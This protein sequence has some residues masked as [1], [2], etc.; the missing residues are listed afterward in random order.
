MTLTRLWIAQALE[1]LPAERTNTILLVATELASNAVRH[2][3]GQFIVR[4]ERTSSFVRIEVEDSGSG[5]PEARDPG[6]HATDGR[7]LQIVNILA[8]AWGARPLQGN[9]GKVVWAIVN[10]PG[11]P[12]R[13][14]SDRVSS[15]TP[16]RAT[17]DDAPPES[18]AS[19][20]EL[21]YAA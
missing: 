19:A 9:T 5:T 21:K 1:D 3:D 15:G 17:P 10:L 12:T 8:D 16:R 7:G 18:T 20:T 13:Q 4:F 2:A 11:D 14:V 6:P